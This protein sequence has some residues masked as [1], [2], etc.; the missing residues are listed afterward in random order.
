MSTMNP[1][2]ADYLGSIQDPFFKSLAEQAIP[3][4]ADDEVPPA[5]TRLEGM[6]MAVRKQLFQTAMDMKDNASEDEFVKAIGAFWN[7][8]LDLCHHLVYHAS[9]KTDPGYKDMNARRLPIILISDCLDALPSVSSCQ[10]YWND[11]VE[12]ALDSVLFGD[13]FWNDEKSVCHLPFL[14]V[15]NQFLK[16]LETSSENTV[17][18]KGRIM[19]ALAKG[20]SI[21]DKSS[22]KVWGSFHSDNTTEFESQTEFDDQDEQNLAAAV[23]S[24]A[25]AEVDYSLYE[26]FWS[27]QSDFANPN[28][29]Q[30]ADFIKKL[31]LV[32]TALESAAS[33]K[34]T[35]SKGDASSITQKYLT[36]SALLPNQLNDPGFRSSVLTQFLIVASHLSSESPPLKNALSTFLVR[37]RKLLLTDNP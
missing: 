27:L 17:E 20:F 26:A 30:V 22:L 24:S 8:T 3:A 32:L 28:R 36:S 6:E 13:L 4:T 33:T 10:K 16:A 2:D 14:K 37:A 21:A 34:S 29:I 15:C 31:R 23:P 5:A 25:A 18:W 35:A 7:S 11:F 9:S 19:W 12:P 1:T